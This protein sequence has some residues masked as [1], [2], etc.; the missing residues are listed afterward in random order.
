MYVP[1]FTL[2]GGKFSIGEEEVVNSGHFGGGRMGGGEIS[3]GVDTL[4]EKGVDNSRRK[5]FGGKIGYWGVK[6]GIF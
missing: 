3:L 4:R 6:K 1:Y 5:C 2:S